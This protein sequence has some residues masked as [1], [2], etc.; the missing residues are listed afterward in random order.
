[1][2]LLDLIYPSYASVNILGVSSLFLN[3][4]QVYFYFLRLTNFYISFGLSH[5]TLK[6]ACIMFLLSVTY[7]GELE[8]RSLGP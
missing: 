2:L 1:M 6:A 5:K 4:S 8:T 7:Q 3:A